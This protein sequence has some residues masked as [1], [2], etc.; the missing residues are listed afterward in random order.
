[1]P[2]ANCSIFNCP[3][4]RRYKDVSVFK[5]PSVANRFKAKLSNDLI[6]IITKDRVVNNSL[7]KQIASNNLYIC[8]RHFSEDQLW[9]YGTKKTM[10][11][12]F[13]TTTSI[14]SYYTKREENQIICQS[15]FEY[16]PP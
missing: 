4:S 8:E 6:N 16:E 13:C 1:M 11:D 14:Y 12:D 9:V 5:F 3:V 15:S 2:G 10:K 7:R